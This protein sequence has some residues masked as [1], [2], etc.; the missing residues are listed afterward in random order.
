MFI[1]KL[2]II[3]RYHAGAL[4]VWF[5]CEI[6]HCIVIYLIDIFLKCL[7]HYSRQHKPRIGENVRISTIILYCKQNQC[8]FVEIWASFVVFVQNCPASRLIYCTQLKPNG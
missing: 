3:P 4:Y 5:Y 6:I 2:K 1:A 7:T 8:D